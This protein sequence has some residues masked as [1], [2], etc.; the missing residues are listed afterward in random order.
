MVPTDTK[1]TLEWEGATIKKEER[2]VGPMTFLVSPFR[3]EIASYQTEDGFNGFKVS[4]KYLPGENPAVEVGRTA[5]LDVSE[6]RPIVQGQIPNI[7][8]SVQR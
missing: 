7:R 8:Q 4:A 3:L 1:F 2:R 5:R 6:L